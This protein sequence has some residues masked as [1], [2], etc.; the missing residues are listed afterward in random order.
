M[1]EFM[2]NFHAAKEQKPEAGKGVTNK[3]VGEIK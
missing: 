1:P 3:H 2:V